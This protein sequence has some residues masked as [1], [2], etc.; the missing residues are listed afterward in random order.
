[1]AAE[2]GQHLV[3]LRA[4]EEGD[5]AARRLLFLVGDLGMPVQLAAEGDEVGDVL[6]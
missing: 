5:D 2:A 1:M 4:G 3:R 6:I